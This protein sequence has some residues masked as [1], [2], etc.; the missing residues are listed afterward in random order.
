MG[1]TQQ[2]PGRFVGLIDDVG[3]R[4]FAVLPDDTWVYPGHGKDATLGADRPHLGEWR[5][6]GWSPP[7]TGGIM[8]TIRPELSGYTVTVE[9]FVPAERAQRMADRLDHRWHIENWTPEAAAYEVAREALEAGGL[10][11]SATVSVQ[12]V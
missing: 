9:V 1:N 3:Q 4:I 12:E 8:P 5:E 6:R 10:T 11:R 7:T 2:C